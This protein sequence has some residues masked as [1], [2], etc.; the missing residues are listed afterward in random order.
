MYS[1]K[2]IGVFL[3]VSK[4]KFKESINSLISIIGQVR[5]EINKFLR[6]DFECIS[7]FHY[8]FVKYGMLLPL[9][10]PTSVGKMIPLGCDDVGV[11]SFG[12]H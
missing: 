5:K 7:S 4:D 8:W 6:N 12:I 1:L 11:W 2:M 9:C 3:I 10:V